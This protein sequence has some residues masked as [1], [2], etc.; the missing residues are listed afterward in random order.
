MTLRLLDAP[1]AAGAV[2]P[3]PAPRP[4]ARRLYQACLDAYWATDAFL[5]A[6][7]QL[8]DPVAY[9]HL[10]DLRQEEFFAVG[11]FKDYHDGRETRVTK[12]LRDLLSGSVILEPAARQR[13]CELLDGPRG[14]DGMLLSR[15]EAELVGAYRRLDPDLQ[16]ALRLIAKTGAQPAAASGA[17]PA[18]VADEGVS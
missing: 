18:V 7:R 16:A 15:Q 2:V 10:D 13:A 11:T 12:Q 9:R 3:L 4:R 6:H 14:R 8:W 1:A 5:K 17:I